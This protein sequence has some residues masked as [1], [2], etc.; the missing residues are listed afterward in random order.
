MEYRYKEHSE[1]HTVSIEETADGYSVTMGDRR[2][3]VTA[4][5]SAARPS[6][7]ALTVDGKHYLAWVTGV[8]DRRLVA[9]DGRADQPHVLTLLRPKR[10]AR[11][12]PGAGPGALEAQMPCV[13]RRVLVAPGER[14]ARGQV[15]AMLEAMKMEIRVTAPSDGIVASVGVAEGQAVEGGQMLIEMTRID[16][17]A[18]HG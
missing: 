11:P 13:V 8:A 2:Y 4:I 15:L 16:E 6:E 3:V 5:V 12:G 10:F 17:A 1:E 14:V 9:L 7:L 18:P